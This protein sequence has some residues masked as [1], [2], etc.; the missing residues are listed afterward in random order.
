MYLSDFN[1][2]SI[3]NLTRKKK[4]VEEAFYSGHGSWGGVG[5]VGQWDLNVPLPV[6]CTARYKGRSKNDC[7]NKVTWI[8]DVVLQR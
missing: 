1:N 3:L 4:D 5:W 7:L 6:T 8:L 2:A